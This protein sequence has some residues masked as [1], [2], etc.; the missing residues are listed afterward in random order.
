[1]DPC[2][3]GTLLLQK[4]LIACKFKISDIFFNFHFNYYYTIDH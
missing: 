2:A 4:A 1:L 3:K